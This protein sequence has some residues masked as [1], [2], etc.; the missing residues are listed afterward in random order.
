MLEK[1]SL[2]DLQKDAN[3]LGIK[4]SKV[5][6]HRVQTGYVGKGKG[7]LQVL[8]ER[9]FIDVQR[10]KDYKIRVEDEDGKV[11]PELSLRHMMQSCTDFANE[12]SQLEH[13]AH[14]LGAHVIITTKYHAEYAGEGVEY[15]WGFSKSVY[16]RH[17]LAAKKGK[18]NFNALVDKCI[19]R[20]LLSV[21]MVR[22][23]SK[24]ARGYMLAYRALESDDMNKQA[25]GPTEITHQMIEKMKKVISSHRAALDFDKGYLNKVV[26][27]DGYD[28]VAEVKSEKKSL[29][30]IERKS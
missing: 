3:N 2:K 16:R 20:K 11:V 6:S 7:Y 29:I 28:F 19:S 18:E 12:V 5:V 17:P 10:L 22:K 25:D 23:F 21:D 9:G 1:K 15:S 26:T 24:R 30:K 4:T 13:V 27:P 8:W 14:C